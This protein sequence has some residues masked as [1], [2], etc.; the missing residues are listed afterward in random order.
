VLAQDFSLYLNNTLYLYLNMIQC[1]VFEYCIL[2]II[3]CILNIIYYILNIIYI[4]VYII[5]YILIFGQIKA[6]NFFS[7]SNSNS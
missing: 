4:I 6:V 1:I 7:Y 2:N 3:Y 5:Y